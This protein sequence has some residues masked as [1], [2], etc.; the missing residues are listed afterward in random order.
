LSE[1][2]YDE[3]DLLRIEQMLANAWGETGRLLA[4]VARRN[5]TFCEEI[6]DHLRTHD[7]LDNRMSVVEGQME[8]Y[9]ATFD[10]M[11]RL[12]DLA[13]ERAREIEQAAQV[14]AA[15]MRV[16]THQHVEAVLSELDSKID[17]KKNAL[18]QLSVLEFG[19]VQRAERAGIPSCEQALATAMPPPSF[20]VQPHEED[21]SSRADVVGSEPSV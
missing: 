4:N 5:L 11:H 3:V 9:A 2:L 6:A 12:L 13:E 20:A 10:Q 15:Q 18:R 21:R 19:M 8:A 16:E 1:G 7:E 17:R 14:E